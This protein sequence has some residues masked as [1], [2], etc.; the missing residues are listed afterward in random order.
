MRIKFNRMNEKNF[1]LIILEYKFL[2]SK[3]IQIL[4]YLGEKK[5]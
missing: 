5:L 4:S 1:S 2:I 3:K